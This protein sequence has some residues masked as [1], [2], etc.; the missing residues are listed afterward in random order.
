MSFL[1]KMFSGKVSG[2]DSRRFLVEAMLG[3]MEADGD[4]S[5]EEMAAFE[6]NLSNH[7]MFEGLSSDELSRLTDLA[8]DALRVAGGGKARLPAIA[9]ALPS[10]NQRLTAYGLAAEICVS[11]KNLAETEIEFLDAMQKAFALGDEETKDVFEAARKHSGLLTLEERSEKVRFLLPMFV[12]CMA[13]MASADEEIHHEERLAMR[14][15][16]RAIPDMAV[17]THAEIDEA[18]D[19]ALEQVAGKDLKK[20]LEGVAAE[21]KASNDR[22]W[23]TCYTMIV[24]LADGVSD[25]REIEFLGNMRTTFGLTE[26]QMDAAMKTAALFP[27]VK[28]G[29]DAP[30]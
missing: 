24:S 5:E 16:L 22:F 29:G 2:E 25:W 11:D 10:R 26:T 23:V 1:R 15:I 8:A 17:L 7:K 14:A 18:I 19:Y 12:R 20:E 6:G 27:A 4:I 13:L 3:A 9:D 28:L 30:E 21:V